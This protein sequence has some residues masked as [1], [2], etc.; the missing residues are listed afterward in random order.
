LSKTGEK[1]TMKKLTIMILLLSI[2]G[3][4]KE[5]NSN[6]DS[7]N[8]QNSDLITVTGPMT[9]SRNY[10]YQF[11][12]K[13]DLLNLQLVKGRYQEDW[14]PSPFIGRGWFGEFQIVI[15]DDSGQIKSVF[16]LNDHF[17]DPLI[18]NALFDIEFDDYNGDGNIDFTIGQYGSSNGSFYKIFTITEDEQ[19]KELKV[20][21]YQD[22]FIS[23][24]NRYS[25]KLEKVNN[26]SFKKTA[27]DNSIGKNVEATFIWDGIEFVR[28]EEKNK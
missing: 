14:S 27:Y 5:T 28:S 4:S 25:T 12:K 11:T 15:L 18:F 1:E 20:K 21:G 17:R 10:L 26:L 8:D 13:N 6:Q 3:C 9:I 22:L 2:I 23:G 7:S 16:R 19:I 24:G